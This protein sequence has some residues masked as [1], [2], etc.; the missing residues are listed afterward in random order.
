MGNNYLR[1]AKTISD[2]LGT[3][4][5]EASAISNLGNPENRL[6][7][8][9]GGASA[10]KIGVTLVETAG[11]KLPGAGTGLTV[12]SLFCTVIQIANDV[13]EPN[14]FVKTKDITSAAGDVAGLVSLAAIAGV[15][16]LSAPLTVGL[17]L[18][19]A[20]LTL[21]SLHPGIQENSLKK[22]IS[23]LS[24][25]FNLHRDPRRFDSVTF[26]DLNAYLALPGS[27]HELV[28]Q[29]QKQK[30]RNKAFPIRPA[31]SITPAMLNRPVMGNYHSSHVVNEKARLLSQLERGL[32][33][34][35]TIKK[36]WQEALITRPVLSTRR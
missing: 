8:V 33:K 29:L 18:V 34:Q 35:P 19:S 24:K 2:I 31:L 17:V 32:H 30:L 6:V 9:S 1:A 26:I 13:S 27:S 3:T 25:Y 7:L 20:G 15:L 28:I 21:I 14:R 11:K 22:D 12:T 23:G 10:A 4:G 16:T 5:D 36:A